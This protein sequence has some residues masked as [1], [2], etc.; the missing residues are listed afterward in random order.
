[1]DIEEFAVWTVAL[2]LV[3]ILAFASFFSADLILKRNAARL[4]RPEGA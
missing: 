3:R 2:G 4:H 1:M